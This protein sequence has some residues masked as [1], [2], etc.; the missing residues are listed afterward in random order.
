MSRTGVI[1]IECE[2]NEIEYQADILFEYNWTGETYEAWLPT[3]GHIGIDEL[4]SDAFG[5][6]NVYSKITCVSDVESKPLK[7]ALTAAA[8][9]AVND[10]DN[11]FSR[12][13]ELFVS[14]TESELN[15]N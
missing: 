1:S 5:T 9:E 3:S 11:D 4:I 7:E 14:S 2:A 10:I 6:V 13:Q 12:L 15:F 8:K